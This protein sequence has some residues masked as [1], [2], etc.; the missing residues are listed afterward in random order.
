VRAGQTTLQP[1]PQNNRIPA[2]AGLAFTVQFAN[3]GNSDESDVRVNVRIGNA[4]PISKT[5]DVT[6]AGSP[7]EVTI[8][9]ATTPAIGTPVSVNVEIMRVRGEM[10]TDNNRQRY[11]VTFTR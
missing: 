2:G 5:I 7:A 6:K 8:P 1:S 10:K 9:V 11:T 4:R 3:Q